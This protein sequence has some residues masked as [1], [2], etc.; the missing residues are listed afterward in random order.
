MELQRE[1]E[2]VKS[3]SEFIV[4]VGNGI[5]AVYA[6][7]YRNY[8]PFLRENTAVA[9]FDDMKYNSE[10]RQAVVKQFEE[11]AITCCPW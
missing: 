5:P 10:M 8:M 1:R 2:R 4:P 3:C 11:K 7:E 9:V 6:A